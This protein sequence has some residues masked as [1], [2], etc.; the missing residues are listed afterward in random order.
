[1][2]TTEVFLDGSVLLMIWYGFFKEPQNVMLL[3]GLLIVLIEIIIIIIMFMMRKKKKKKNDCVT[4]DF[5]A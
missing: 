5:S 3:V 4:L 2:R 1:M